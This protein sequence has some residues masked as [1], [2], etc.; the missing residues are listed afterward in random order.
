MQAH[1]SKDN[2]GVK[3]SK[4]GENTFNIY[5]TSGQDKSQEGFHDYCIGC[6]G[7]DAKGIPTFKNDYRWV[8]ITGEIVR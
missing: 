4:V 3:V 2:L 6:V 1:I 8:E 7:F 5:L